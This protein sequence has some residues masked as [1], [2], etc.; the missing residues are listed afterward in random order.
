MVRE[1]F[2]AG[3]K[4]VVLSLPTGAGKTVVAAEMIRRV[5]ANGGRCVFTADR[6]SLVAQTSARLHEAGM[7]HGVL[8]GANTRDPGASVLVC[9][10]QTLAT[11]GF[12]GDAPKLVVIDECHERQASSLRVLDEFGVHCVGLT[13]TPF[14]AGMADVFDSLVSPVTTNELIEQGALAPVSAFVVR[15]VDMRG[16]RVNRLGEWSGRDVEERSRRVLGDIVATWRE[17]VFKRFGGPAKTLVFSATVAHGAEL[18]AEFNGAGFDFR[19]VSFREPAAARR[20][21]DAFRAGDCLGLVSC[22][23][24]AK[25]FDVPDAR[26]LVAARPYRRSLARHVQQLGRV[27]RAA[28]GK[29]VALV[30]DHSGNFLRFAERTESFWERGWGA[31]SELESEEFRANGEAAGGK[32]GRKCPECGFVR[33]VDSTEC[34]ECGFREVLVVEAE[35]EEYKRPPP[36][37]ADMVAWGDCDDAWGAVCSWVARKHPNKGEGEATWQ[38][39]VTFRDVVGESSR[40]R[41]FRLG[42]AHAG[43]DRE[44][45]R[46]LRAWAQRRGVTLGEALEA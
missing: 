32:P 4:R 3:D 30:L 12:P 21:I 39:R 13:A 33:A 23:V 27:M 26:V 41:H 10:A 1:R 6:L 38:A 14:T 25:G 34:A 45:A 40:E 17:R 5:V 7:A 43:V 9:S 44:A 29:D 19:H 2:L 37:E 24:L 42:P 18:A 8:Q 28:P 15:E 11:R 20:D 31:L 22:E 35:L 16:A 36:A 46:A